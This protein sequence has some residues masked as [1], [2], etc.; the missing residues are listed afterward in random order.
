M[1]LTRRIAMQIALDHTSVPTRDKVAT[2]EFFARVFGLTYEGPRRDFAP[3]TISPTLTFNFEEVASFEPHH[4]AFRVR[5]DD[6]DDIVRRLEENGVPYGG[7]PH[8]D[9]TVIY[10]RAGDRGLYFDDPNGHGL[11]VIARVE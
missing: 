5:A 4:Y 11:E 2:A 10:E 3:L 9:D 6:F 1:G 7:R 8:M